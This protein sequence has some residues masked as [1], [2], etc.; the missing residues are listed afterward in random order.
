M[1]VVALDRK[2]VE[3]QQCTHQ[4]L[5]PLIFTLLRICPAWIRVDQTIQKPMVSCNKNWP[6]LKKYVKNKRKRSN[7]WSNMRCASNKFKRNMKKKPNWRRKR[8][9]SIKMLSGPKE[10]RQK[11]KRKG[12]MPV[13][14][15]NRCKKP[16]IRGWGT[17][18]SK[19]GRL[20]TWRNR[21]K[22]KRYKSRK[23]L[24]ETMKGR[25]RCSSK[26]LRPPGNRRSKKKLCD[27]G[28]NSWQSVTGSDLNLGR[29]RIKLGLII[30]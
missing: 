23:K 10:G 3:N 2:L 21:P 26:Q 8:L 15:R 25:W 1:L 29:N 19:E 5:R 28:K 30:H 12:M 7:K 9:K 18:N 24:K 13:E 27:S 14:S 6:P 4:D 16:R 17:P 11:R 20:F 22:W